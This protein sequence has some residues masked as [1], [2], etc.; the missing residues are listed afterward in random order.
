MEGSSGEKIF[1]YSGPVVK[2]AAILL[3]L[4]AVTVFLFSVPQYSNVWHQSRSLIQKLFF[5]PLLLCA[6]W[7]GGAGAVAATAVVTVVAGWDLLGQ[8]TE[9]LGMKIA[10]AGELGV[11]WL[12]GGLAANFFERQKD[13]LRSMESANENTLLALAAAL[14]VREHGTGLHSHRVA[15][16]TIRLAGE[17]KITDPATLGVLWKGAMLH[18]VGKI[19]IPDS[20]LLKP[21]ALSEEE[22]TVMRR[23][24]D[25]GYELIRKFDF[26]REP[27]EIVLAHHEHYDGSGYPRGLSE[28]AIPLGS[29][30]FAVIDVYDA[31]TTTRPYH[32]PSS[33]SRA[34]EILRQG[35]GSHFDP[36]VVSAFE[37]V[38]LVDWTEIARRT[39]RTV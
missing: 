13:Y 18:D 35:S 24:P 2:G 7:F 17:M 1:G 5:I 28:D 30:L 21:G 39:G 22:W 29:R 34:L 26:L 9:D 8:R 4:G 36:A 10:G 25:V 3:L 20:V 37:R 38:P 33:H 27:A 31:I 19:G 14:D 16:Y 32:S 15:D 23:H 11:F 6:A 12:V